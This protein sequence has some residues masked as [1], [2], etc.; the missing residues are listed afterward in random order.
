MQTDKAPVVGFGP[1][2]ACDL[3]TAKQVA[4]ELGISRG[5]LYVLL[6]GDDPPPVYQDGGPG[7]T[8][9]ASSCEL[10]AWR[11]RRARQ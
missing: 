2:Q 10:A 4:D 1:V 5:T 6:R 11:A 8:M 3:T 9:R 7:S